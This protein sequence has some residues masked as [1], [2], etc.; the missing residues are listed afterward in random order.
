MALI[1]PD[2]VLTE[3]RRMND[4]VFVDSNVF[5]YLQSTT[6]IDKRATAQRV[7]NELTCVA[8][9]QVLNEVSSV[10]SRRA[11][12][13]FDQ[14]GRIVDGI[15]QVCD[16]AIVTYDTVRKAHDIAKR[17]QLGYYDSLIISSAIE[18]DCEYL[19]SEDMSD[20]QIIDGKLT[21]VNIFAHP[22]FFDV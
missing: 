17:C 6:E 15:V 13:S 4:R 8:S 10:L 21:I 9:T 16:I 2:I 5:I 7:V 22:E 18:S 20:G 19:L 14:I 1:L 11:R 12:F 3:K